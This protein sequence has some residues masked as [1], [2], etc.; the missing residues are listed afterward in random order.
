MTCTRATKI[1]KHICMK[2]TRF[3]Y[4][5][6]FVIALRTNIHAYYYCKLQNNKENTRLYLLIEEELDMSII[7]N[8]CKSIEISKSNKQGFGYSFPGKLLSCACT[9]R[10]T[11]KSLPLRVIKKKDKLAS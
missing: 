4:E 1:I 8:Q 10:N 3:T 5:S 6:I 11:V 7:L 9:A 2:I